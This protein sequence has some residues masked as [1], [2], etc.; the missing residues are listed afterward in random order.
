[1]HH[2]P[3]RGGTGW[4]CKAENA[5][6]AGLYYEIANVGKMVEASKKRITWRIK[7]EE[8]KEYEISLTHSI[9]SGKKILRVDGIV[10]YQSTAFSLGDWDYVFNL[11]N[12]VLHCIIKP[13]VE[14][15]DS[16]DLI[17]DGVSFRRLPE[18]LKPKEK[19]PSVR[20]LQ[21]K[22]KSR[23]S[24]TSD[25]SR[26]A[27]GAWECSA[28]TL[29]NEKPMAPVCEACGTPKPRHPVT[30]QS[31]TEFSRQTSK[32]EIEIPKQAPARPVEFNPFEEAR[33]PTAP[34]DGFGFDMTKNDP[35]AQANAGFNQLEQKRTGSSDQIVS[36]LQG[37]DFSYQPPPPAPIEPVQPKMEVPLAPQPP[38]DP[39][40][41]AGI[42]NLD[43]NP[44][45]KMPKLK[46]TT[47]LQT[48]EQARLSKP[49]EIQ[50]PVMQPPPMAY[51][52]YPPAYNG[53]P[54]QQHIMTAPVQ[55]PPFGAYNMGNSTT[56]MNPNYG[57]QQQPQVFM[58]HMTNVPPAKARP[59]DPFATL[60]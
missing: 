51:G 43:L 31:S 16:Y 39:L 28:C 35:F 60:S 21:S 49:K 37:L 4:D 34:N 57:M 19:N 27:S 14:L 42:V 10:A 2:R 8:G 9:A 48:L 17:V 25:L 32:K 54:G 12:H 30:R 50:Q 53:Y 36:M 23:E 7:V 15:N 29:I 5:K 45:D 11:G 59:S 18:Q 13:S 33:S 58:P 6:A 3:T 47:S 56:M 41:G 52:Q 55:Q 44:Q 24:S 38:S 22:P 46:P 20:T 1:M 40:W 26:T